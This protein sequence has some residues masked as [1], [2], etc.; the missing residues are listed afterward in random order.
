LKPPYVYRTPEGQLV[1]SFTTAD[2]RERTRP[3]SIGGTNLAEISPAWWIR[4]IACAI[5]DEIGA[6]YTMKQAD[7]DCTWIVELEPGPVAQQELGQR[8]HK[9]DKKTVP[10]TLGMVAGTANARGYYA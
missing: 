5:L 3:K 2:I 4:D 6:T 10:S 1:A 9:T 8:T 7:I